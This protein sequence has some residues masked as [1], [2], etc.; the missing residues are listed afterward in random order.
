MAPFFARSGPVG[1]YNTSDGFT[2]IKFPLMRISFLKVAVIKA[3]SSYIL[4]VNFD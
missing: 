4:S 1:L 3:F 2:G